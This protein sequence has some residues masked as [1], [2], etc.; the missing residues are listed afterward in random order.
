MSENESLVPFLE[1]L[2]DVGAHY[3]ILS[4]GQQ[5]ELSSL[6]NPSA[7]WWSFN[8]SVVN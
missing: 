7:V 3:F 4:L 5:I 2:C 6:A 8:T 1:E